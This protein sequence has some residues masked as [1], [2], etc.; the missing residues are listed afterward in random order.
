MSTSSTLGRIGVTTFTTPTDREIVM[1]R[2][3]DAPR[4]LVFEVWTN[5][6]HLP[7]WLLGPSGWTMPVCEVDLRPGGSW[8]IVWR[9]ADG[10]EMGM[11]GVYREIAPPERL[12]FTETWGGD[13]PETLNTMVLREEAGKTTMT[14]TMLYP[15]K[16][17]RDRALKTGMKDGVSVSFDRLAEILPT[18]T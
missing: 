1:A 2:T 16:E 3:F 8:H 6:E 5:P 14:L 13:W 7:R 4:R 11:T 9:H 10:N 15:S 17:S 12:V 18:M